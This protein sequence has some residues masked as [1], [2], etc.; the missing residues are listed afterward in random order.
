MQSVTTRY[1]NL[2]PI[3]TIP[4]PYKNGM[5]MFRFGLPATL[6]RFLAGIK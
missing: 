4:F 5:D 6:N 1:T 3:Y 2:G